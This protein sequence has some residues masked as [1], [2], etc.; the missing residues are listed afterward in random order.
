MRWGMLPG[1]LITSRH[2]VTQPWVPSKLGHSVIPWHSR[3]QQQSGDLCLTTCPSRGWTWTW[4]CPDRCQLMC[5]G[6]V[7]QL[8][9]CPYSF[10]CQT[11]LLQL[12]LCL[13]CWKFSHCRASGWEAHC[14]RGGSSSID[15]SWNLSP[16]LLFM[17]YKN[18]KK[19]WR[20]VLHPETW[21]THDL[22]WTSNA[23]SHRQNFST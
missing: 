10:I 6:S 13:F 2:S 15:M 23:I 14:H 19:H 5:S 7:W 9:M 4:T 17:L 8:W 22:L 1:S 12:S 18:I 3:H 21:S 11:T 20:S 16:L